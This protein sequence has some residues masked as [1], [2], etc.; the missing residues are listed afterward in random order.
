VP[1]EYYG[2]SLYPK[3]F[4]QSQALILKGQIIYGN[5]FIHQLYL[6]IS[7]NRHREPQTRACLR[8][9]VEP[10]CQKIAKIGKG[11]ALIHFAIQQARA[12]AM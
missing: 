11:L 1:N 10:G 9:S 7:M 8:C 3:V 4:H 12:V 2:S 6:S 5:Y